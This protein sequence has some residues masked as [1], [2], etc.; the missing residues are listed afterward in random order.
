MCD[1]NDGNRLQQYEWQGKVRERQNVIERHQ[2]RSFVERRQNGQSDAGSDCRA[3]RRMA[4]QRA[5][6]RLRRAP[7]RAPYER[8]QGACGHT[9]SA[10]RRRDGPS[11]LSHSRQDRRQ[12]ACSSFRLSPPSRPAVPATTMWRNNRGCER[13]CRRRRV[14]AGPRSIAIEAAS[15]MSCS[16]NGFGRKST[17]PAFIARTDIRTSPC[18]VI[19]TTGR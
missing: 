4:K 17:A 9:F 10:S 13:N 16:R 1:G 11:P 8:D 2:N 12:P 19:R 7:V 18:P 5:V 6:A 3:L 14:A 15:I